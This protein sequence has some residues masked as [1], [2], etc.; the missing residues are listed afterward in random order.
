MGRPGRTPVTGF[1][2]SGL[3]VTTPSSGS[4]PLTIF[5]EVSGPLQRGLFLEIGTEKVAVENGVEI[6]L[7]AKVGGLVDGFSISF[8]CWRADLDVRQATRTTLWPAAPAPPVAARR[9]GWPP[10]RRTARRAWWAAALRP[11]AESV[12]PQ[13]RATGGSEALGAVLLVREAHSAQ[14]HASEMRRRRRHT[15]CAG[16]SFALCGGPATAG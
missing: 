12:H 2:S 7:E 5:T 6:H 13:G 3:Q 11:R 8:G 16:Q 9:R 1:P 10:A 14:S 15:S 4:D